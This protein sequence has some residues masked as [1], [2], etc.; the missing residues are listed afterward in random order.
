M[1]ISTLGR[2]LESIGLGAKDKCENQS[3]IHEISQGIICLGFTEVCDFETFWNGDHKRMR[4]IKRV[5]GKIV[6]ALTLDFRF[7]YGAG[8]KFCKVDIDL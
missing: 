1:N 3:E 4:A 6:F 8:V 2:K 5:K 7:G